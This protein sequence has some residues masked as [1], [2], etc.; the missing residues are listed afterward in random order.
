MKLYTTSSVAEK[1]RM[2]EANERRKLE[3]IQQQQQQQLQL[4]QQQL[5]QQQ[6]L[7][8]QKIQQEMQMHQEDN[9]AKVLIAQI[10]GVAEAQRLAMM[11]KE[12]GI[13]AD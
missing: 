12:D 8:E 5:Q 6:Q 13:T 11:N 9:D 7:G 2:V 10:N 3:Q 4:Q 1:Q